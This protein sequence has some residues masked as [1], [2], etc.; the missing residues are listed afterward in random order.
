MDSTDLSELLL[1]S[2]IRI[3]CTNNQTWSLGTGFFFAF[4]CDT[5]NKSIPVIVTN[6]HVIDGATDGK[7]IFSLC[8]EEKKYIP[9]KTF[10]YHISDFEE[11]W[12]PHPDKNVD[13][14]VLPLSRFYDNLKPE[15]GH[16]YAMY[17]TEDHLL[18]KHDW[19]DVS[20]IEEVTI[21]GYPD[22]VWDTQNHLPLVRRGITASSIHYDFDGQP[23]FIVDAAIFPGSSGSPIYL[24]NSGI[25]PAR[26]GIL[27]GNRLR[28]LGI[29]RA[30]KVHFLAGEVYDPDNPNTNSKRIE[31]KV[32]NGLGI[33]SHARKLL[34]F[35]AVF[36]I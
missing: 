28:L 9:G 24:Y 36:G 7:L 15:D 11:A 3:E 35:K 31:L 25:F 30:V 14:C 34:D 22:G 23:E 12:I 33:A 5:S 6:K 1:H 17:L 32:P 16:I 27:R 13:L 8:D 29:N 21:V 19:D 26:D 2:T 4:S 10:I 18:S 20:H